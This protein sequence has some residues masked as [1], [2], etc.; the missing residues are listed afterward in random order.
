MLHA[1]AEL[2][3]DALF[4]KRVIIAPIA[5]PSSGVPGMKKQRPGRRP[6][7]A[8][9]AGRTDDALRC[10]DVNLTVGVDVDDG[11]FA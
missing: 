8:P 1:V 4:L 5:P 7:S 9:V 11:E 10:I 6:K 2:G 3:I